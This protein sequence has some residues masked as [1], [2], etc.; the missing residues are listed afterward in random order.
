MCACEFYFNRFETK[1]KSLNKRKNFHLSYNKCTHYSHS[2]SHTR[3]K[4]GT[5]VVRVCGTHFIY[6]SSGVR[7]FSLPT[8]SG[9]N[10]FSKSTSSDVFIVSEFS[11]SLT[12]LVK[13]SR[14]PESIYTQ[15]EYDVNSITIY[16]LPCHDM[17]VSVYGTGVRKS[18][19][20]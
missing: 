15:T 2:M 19:L 8:S 13:L 7:F 3:T 20:V 11:S 17:H 4:H 5:T 10:S 6:V 1:K 18:L 12:E 9:R 16:A 14:S